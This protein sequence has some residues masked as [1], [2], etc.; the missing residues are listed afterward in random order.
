MLTTIFFSQ[1]VKPHPQALSEIFCC[2]W[3]RKTWMGDVILPFS[4]FLLSW[5][6]KELTVTELYVFFLPHETRTDK[7]NILIHSGQLINVIKICITLA[8]FE[9][10]WTLFT[11]VESFLELT[12]CCAITSIHYF[13]PTFQ[14]PDFLLLNQSQCRVAKLCSMWLGERMHQKNLNGLGLTPSIWEIQPSFTCQKWNMDEIFGLRFHL[15]L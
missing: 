10:S 4:F 9:L 8:L 5:I 1:V 15:W 14:C 13:F 6:N 2:C 3:F 11:S 12:N 7:Q